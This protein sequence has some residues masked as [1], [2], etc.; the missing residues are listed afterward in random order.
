MGEESSRASS[1]EA[2]EGQAVP[3]GCQLACGWCRREKQLL[4]AQGPQLAES[5]AGEAAG[6]WWSPGSPRFWPRH[7]MPQP[8]GSGAAGAHP[9][10]H[11]RNSSLLGCL[12]GSCPTGPIMGDI[13][14][15]I[16]ILWKTAM[17]I[18]CPGSPY[19]AELPHASLRLGFLWAH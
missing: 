19:I 10:S 1:W 8:A 13:T 4:P 18:T 15:G 9:C 17:R 11:G 14:T 7:H 5:E 3:W 12:R 6:C 2:R 16:F